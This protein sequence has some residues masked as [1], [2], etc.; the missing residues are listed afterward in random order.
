[1][2][3]ILVKF[4][5][6]KTPESKTVR[7]DA[8]STPLSFFWSDSLFALVGSFELIFQIIGCSSTPIPIWSLTRAPEY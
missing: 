1:M 3:K 8:L 7:A 2:A 5:K 4:T 6:L